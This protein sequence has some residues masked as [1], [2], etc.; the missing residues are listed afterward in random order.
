MS[1]GW[2]TKPV[3][4]AVGIVGDIHNVLSARQALDALNGR[5][6]DAGAPKFS[7]ARRL[8]QRVLNGGTTSEQAREAFVA[9]AREARILVE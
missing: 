6:P 8:C 3:A 2:F 1:E 9:A 7:E 5:W 4:I